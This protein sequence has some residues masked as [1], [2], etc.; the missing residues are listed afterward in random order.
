MISA[1]EA[2]LVGWPLLAAVVERTEWMRRRV[3]FALIGFFYDQTHTR[4]LG[5]LGG[6]MEKLPFVGVLFVMMAMASL[7]LPGFANFASE[8]AV[9]GAISNNSAD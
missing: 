9:A 6:L 1:A 2:Q 4:M 8:F 3:A 7:G 5:D